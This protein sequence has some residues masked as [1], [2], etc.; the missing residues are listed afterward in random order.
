MRTGRRILL[1]AGAGAALAMVF[2]AYLRPDVM[3][4]LANQLWNCF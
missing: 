4:T 1:W 2:A 3:V